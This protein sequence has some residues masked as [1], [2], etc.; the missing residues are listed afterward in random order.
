[1]NRAVVQSF[2]WDYLKDY[3]KLE[4]E[5]VLGALG[6]PSRHN[7]QKVAD[8]EKTLDSKWVDH[9][10]GLGARLVV[11]NR[12]ITSEAVDHAHRLGMK[13]WV[14]TI[15]DP[16]VAKRLLGQNV[17]GLITNNPSLIC[18]TIALGLTAR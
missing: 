10:R 5:Q 16:A 8:S 3:H 18:R 4:P 1:M 2:D 11:W 9:V 14:Y 6:P 15:D 12:E 17:D 13:V 7:G